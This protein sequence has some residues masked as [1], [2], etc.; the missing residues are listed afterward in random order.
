MGPIRIKATGLPENYD[1]FLLLFIDAYFI[2]APF[3][4]ADGMGWYLPPMVTVVWLL[5]MMLSEM[6]SSLEDPFGTD[7]NDLPL[8]KYCTAVELQIAAVT[9]RY[10]PH[11]DLT[12]PPSSRSTLKHKSRKLFRRVSSS[13]RF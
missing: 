5:M 1:S 9:A 4:W 3:A 2:V 11:L 7:A 6:G 8:D 12:L 13:L 10:G